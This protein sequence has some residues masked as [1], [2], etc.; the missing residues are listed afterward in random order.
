MKKITIKDFLN[1]NSLSGLKG[2]E[3]KNTLTFIRT[4]P[5]L[6]KNSYDH[7]LYMKQNEKVSRI[8][9]FS[10]SPQYYW[11]DD[12]TLLL[13]TN[14]QK[15]LDAKQTA[16]SKYDINNGE[17][18]NFLTL[19]IPLGNLEVV[20]SNSLLITSN[21]NKDD[22]ILLDQENRDAYIK[23]LKDNANF[24][25]IDTVPFQSN[26]SGFTRNKQQHTFIYSIDDDS[27]K[28]ITPLTK[29]SKLLKYDKKK[30]KIYFI[31]TDATEVPEF[32][33]DLMV[34]D[35]LSDTYTTLYNKRD[36]S[37]SRLFVLKDTLYVFANSL[38]EYGINQNND[39]YRV[40][41]GELIKVCDFGLSDHNSI[42][43]DVR[44]GMSPSSLTLDNEYL[45]IGTYHNRTRLYSF[46]GESI[47]TI[48][49]PVGSLDGIIDT[50]EGLIGV[51][52]YD[53]K[54]QELYKLNTD[55]NS[56]HQITHFN[57][58]ILNS[59]YVAKPVHIPYSNNGVNLDGWVLLPKEYDPSKKYPGILDIHGGPKT[60]Y[61]DVYYHEMQ[62][63]AN[64][65][66]IVFFTN[67]R[68]GDAF[69]DNFADIRGKYGTIDYSDIMKFTDIVLDTYSVDKDRVGVTGGSY[70]GF[71]T[72]W[73]VSHT[74]RFKAAATQRSIS[75]WIS[76]Y[77]TSDIGVYFGKDQTASDP[78]T[79]L[80]KM[81]EQSPLKHALN[82]KTPL[83]FIH[84]D[85]DYRCP[86]EQAM[87]L[88]T[89]VKTNGI[90][91][92]FVWFKGENHDLSRSGRPQSRLRRLEEITNWFETRLK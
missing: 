3:T 43:S 33:G 75:N 72:N 23:E 15:E 62:V 22:F 80:D 37:I 91:T 83:L 18:S 34:Y 54:L 36:L 32:Y 44:F 6:D 11:Y 71:M 21:L 25:V 64:L 60:I 7:H 20:N 26:G 27:F 88:Y 49:D 53:S 40:I 13:N 89:V 61:S 19:P 17:I 74:N 41:D 69:D 45:F 8:H 52:L 92:R 87:Q 59:K 28:H 39:I 73:I 66:Y 5:N 84:S 29:N 9:S 46:N 14:S 77:G 63:W 79:S 42:G 90:D 55:E 4:V 85:E 12:T 1:I 70:G 86:I 38:K 58:K 68:G 51:G 76:F 78:F 24:E 10:G 48:F 56:V 82:I 50:H 81:W 31:Q 16:L 35:I 65:G 2:N 57:D 67:P 47:S 30:Q